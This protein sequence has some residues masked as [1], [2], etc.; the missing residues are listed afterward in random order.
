[1]C[2]PNIPRPGS[3]TQASERHFY[4]FQKKILRHTIPTVYAVVVTCGTV[5]A[6]RPYRIATKVAETPE[7]SAADRSIEGRTGP[8]SEPDGP[9]RTPGT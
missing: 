8:L 5:T 3:I 2:D 1:M 9:E 4:R 7:D 6:T